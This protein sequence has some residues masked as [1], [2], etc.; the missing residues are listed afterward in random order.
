MRARRARV[1]APPAEV[2]GLERTP[3]MV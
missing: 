3:V 2:G 1:E